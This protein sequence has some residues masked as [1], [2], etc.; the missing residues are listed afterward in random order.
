MPNNK[1]TNIQTYKR[2]KQSKQTNLIEARLHLARDVKQLLEL[3]PDG[4]EEEDD[5]E[6]HHDDGSEDPFLA[7]AQLHSSEAHQDGRGNPD[8]PL[9]EGEEI[10]AQLLRGGGVKREDSAAPPERDTH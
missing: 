8:P 2:I 3:L 9:E 5:G 6:D 7:L 1:H 4:S 10:L